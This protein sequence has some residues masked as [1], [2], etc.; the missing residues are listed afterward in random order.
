MGNA[1][2]LA[3]GTEQQVTA[4]DLVRHFGLWQERAGRAPVYVLHRGRPRLV[5]T[6]LD[7]MDALCAPHASNDG[8]AQASLAA[9]LD[10]DEAVT[11]VVGRG[12]IIRFASHGARARF[13][14][15]VVA[16]APLA[17]LPAMAGDLLLDAVARVIET[18]IAEDVEFTWHRF[19]TR[20]QHCRILPFPDG[21]VLH[22]EDA[23]A[24]DELRVMA[25][26]H[27]ATLAALESAGA[28]SVRI[29]LR[30]HIEAPPLT[31]ARATGIAVDALAA[32]RFVSLFDVAG[33]VAVGG[34]VE[35][36][37]ATAAPLSVDAALLVRGAVPQ[38][39]TIG[40]APIREAGQVV[41]LIATIVTPPSGA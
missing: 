15:A 35:Q 13:G 37:I 5:L 4:S 24:V 36:A 27:G 38:P 17:A 10:A 19:P 12:G 2:P 14:A 32:A 41:A 18:G 29:G 1:Q 6:S 28:I 8:D 7:V 26:V 11:I 31:L 30:G 33:R 16:G 22:A 3:A 25:Q 23:G 39:V 34:A 20:R 21:C 40:L 9:L